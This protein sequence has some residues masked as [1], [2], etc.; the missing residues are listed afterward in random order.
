[1]EGYAS[2][3]SAVFDHTL[4]GTADSPCIQGIGRQAAFRHIFTLF[5]SGL[6]RPGKMAVGYLPVIKAGNASGA[7]CPEY[8]GIYL[9]AFY[10]AIIVIA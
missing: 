3:I 8:A 10:P 5:Q 2:L 4:V 9:T 1:M 7:P 6:Q